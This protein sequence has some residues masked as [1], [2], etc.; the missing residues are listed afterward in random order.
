MG[1]PRE[2]QVVTPEQAEAMLRLIVDNRA[3][4]MTLSSADCVYIIKGG[5]ALIE[6]ATTDVII[7]KLLDEYYQD[8][9]FLSLF[10]TTFNYFMT[11]DA[12]A[13]KLV[14]KFVRHLCIVLSKVILTGKMC[15]LT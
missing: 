12:F 13:A 3:A 5:T 6:S 2:I 9:D 14:E 1:V 4:I 10:F 15:F 7:E 11:H 8:L